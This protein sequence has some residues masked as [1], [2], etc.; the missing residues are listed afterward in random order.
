M[1]I[2]GRVKSCLEF[3]KS[4]E[5]AADN[6]YSKCPVLAL[7]EKFWS[8]R[9]VRF[10]AI[11]AI[12]TLFGYALYAFLVFI[13]IPYTFARIMSIIIGVIFNFFTTGR[14]VFKNRDN[15]LIIRF[16]LVY[17]FTMTL[18]VLVLRRLV[19]G[20][21]INEYLAGAMVTVPIALLSFLLNS[22]F[23][24]KTIKLFPEE[25]KDAS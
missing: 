14:V 1:C 23:T 9:F 3:D 12:N 4:I 22:I 15:G 6:S 21:N 10:L 2:I 19:A 17:V 11:G 7:I 8:V 13:G 24:F 16:I 5:E 20:L 18:D 25:T